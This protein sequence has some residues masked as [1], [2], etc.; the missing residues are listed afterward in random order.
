MRKFNI[1]KLIR[2]G[3]DIGGSKEYNLWIKMQYV[4]SLGRVTRVKGIKK[5]EILT[6]YTFFEPKIVY[7]SNL[8]FICDIISTVV[9][10]M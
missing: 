9:V 7:Y 3:M 5:V 8:K 6:P 10:N 1:N 4:L 2:E